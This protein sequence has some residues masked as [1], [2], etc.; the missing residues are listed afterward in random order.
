MVTNLTN[1]TGNQELVIGE[2]CKIG[3][4]AKVFASVGSRSELSP[5]CVISA[6]VGNGCRVGVKVVLDTPLSDHNNVYATAKQRHCLPMT[7]SIVH[8]KHLEYLMQV[9]PKYH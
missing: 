4:G 2:G 7:E 5:F 6:E 3:V 1:S 9:L 8:D